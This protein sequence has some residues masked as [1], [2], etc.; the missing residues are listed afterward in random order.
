MTQNWVY[1][2]SSGYLF[3][4]FC[5]FAAFLGGRMHGELDLD[6]ILA[7]LSVLEH[8]AHTTA[9]RTTRHRV[10]LRA[11]IPAVPAGS[12]LQLSPDTE[13]DG[14][15]LVLGKGSMYCRSAVTRNHRVTVK[16]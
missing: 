3:L 6:A 7:A 14:I 16:L 10:G 1:R 2:E 4:I 5:L 11:E 13:Q 12:K 8:L 15:F 9:N